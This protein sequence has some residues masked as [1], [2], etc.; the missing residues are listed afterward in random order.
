MLALLDP[1][2]LVAALAAL[3]WAFGI[4]GALLVTILLFLCQPAR[5]AW[6]GGSLLRTPWLAALCI[7]LALCH[8]R[9]PVAAQ[10]QN[11]GNSDYGSTMAAAMTSSWCNVDSGC[12]WT[13]MMLQILSYL[14]RV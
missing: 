10:C 5:W 11:F 6:T 9:R 3:A 14:I 2:L 12:L 7:G 4:R 13:Q 8:R 1:L